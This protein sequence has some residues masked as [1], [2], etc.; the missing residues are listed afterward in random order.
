MLA[1]TTSSASFSSSSPGLCNGVRGKAVRP[2][3]DDSRMPKGAMRAMKESM[4]AGFAD[5][6]RE[7]T[8]LLATAPTQIFW[9]C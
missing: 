4:R 1:S 3:R 9:G 2:V 5:L 7:R 6:F 8:L